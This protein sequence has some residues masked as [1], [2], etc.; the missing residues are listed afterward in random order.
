[1]KMT[2]FEGLRLLFPLAITAHNLEEAVWLPAWSNTLGIQQ[3]I[4]NRGQFWFGAIILTILAYVLTG[5]SIRAGK[6]ARSTYLLLGY[7]FAMLGNVIFPHLLAT[8]IF[9]RYA[10]G[11][12]TAILFNAPIMTA[13]WKWAIQEKYITLRKGLIVSSYVTGC[14]LLSIPVLFF[15]G[16]LLLGNI[17]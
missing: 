11:L 12:S 5:L 13:L 17:V 4:V 14:L 1:M 15:I 9:R 6:E 10:P 16:Q 8:I 7:A 3:L 2:K